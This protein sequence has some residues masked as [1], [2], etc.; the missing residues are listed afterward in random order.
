MK[1]SN[2]NKNWTGRTD[3]TQGMLHLLISLLRRTDPR[4]GYFLMAFT[5]PYYLLFGLGTRDMYHFYRQ[6]GFGR[7]KAALSVVRCE[8]TFGKTV[9]D[10]FAAYAGRKFDVKVNG[11][12]IFDNLENQASGFVQFSSHVGCY[13]MAGYFIGLTKKKLNALVYGGE[14]P[15]VM[16]NRRQMM[17]ANNI[18]MILV[19]NDL[20]HVVEVNAALDR[21][22]VVSIPADRIFG[23]QKSVECQFLGR[24]A[25]LP[26]GPFKVALRK[27]VPITSV[28]VMK[29]AWNSY[30]VNVMQIHYDSSYT[31]QNLA[32]QFA[33][34]LETMA[35]KYPWQ[36][37]NFFDFWKQ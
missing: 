30:S 18:N 3:G 22:E 9:I 6:L 32:Q 31:P 27:R 21:G 23:S 11:K 7:V 16:E 8:F 5:I 14:S 24:T 25:R 15:V 4:F 33:N 34:Q 10:K 26:L 13:E 19:G 12:E 37:F 29:E 20:S 2:A 35:R 28:F 36:W 1:A 17:T